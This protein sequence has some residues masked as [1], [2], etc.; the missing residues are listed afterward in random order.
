MRTT[1]ANMNN[2]HYIRSRGRLGDSGP[3]FPQEIFDMVIDYLHGD[4][5]ALKECSLV[6]RSWL[7]S[8]SLHLL[9]SVRWPPPC[10]YHRSISRRRKWDTQLLRPCLPFATL[11]HRIQ[12]SARL[13]AIR[14]LRLSSYRGEQRSENYEQLSFAALR[15]IIDSLPRLRKLDVVSVVWGL[16][17]LAAHDGGSP[18]TIE[19]LRCHPHSTRI[20]RLPCLFRHIQCLEFVSATDMRIPPSFLP[21][22]AV[23][24]HEHRTEVDSVVLPL[25]QRN[26]RL[27]ILWAQ[28]KPESILRLT[29]GEDSCG[30]PNAL[31]NLLQSAG[32]VEHVDY[33]IYPP[34]TGPLRS[35]PLLRYLTIRDDIGSSFYF[36]FTPCFLSVRAAPHVGY[37]LRF[38]CILCESTMVRGKLN[39]RCECFCD[40]GMGC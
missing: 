6:C 11:V 21:P 36:I 12:T 19:V 26:A 16:D 4:L 28:L 18:R 2:N 38:T 9:E 34:T 20:V 8:S 30:Y 22:I 5:P 13:Q 24:C 32:N 33:R 1:L 40:R 29:L 15:T 10:R 37:Y 14:S 3:L 35:W 17:Y 27:G 7:T 23:Q 25:D 39:N 31:F